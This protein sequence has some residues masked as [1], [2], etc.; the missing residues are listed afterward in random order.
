MIRRLI[1]MLAL[2]LAAPTMAA[3]PAGIWAFRIGNMT[4]FKI[5]LRHRGPDWSA[6]W[7]RSSD[8][9][10]DADGKLKTG[11]PIIKR[12]ATEARA[13]PDGT[14]EVSFDDPRPGATPDVFRIRL[15]DTRRA[16]AYYNGGR[17]GAI[18]LARATVK[19]R[20]DAFGRPRR[21]T[22]AAPDRDWP[23]NAEMIALFA[24]DQADRNVP[25]IDW[26][27]VG[28]RDQERRART[29][30]LIDAGALHSGDDFLHAAFVFQ[31]GSG[32][33]DFLKAHILATVAVAR[34]NRGAIW[35]ASATLDRYLQSIG[36]PQATGTQFSSRNGKWTQDPYNRT[37][38]SD[39]LRQALNVPPLDEQE[40]QRK[41]YEAAVKN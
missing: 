10:V 32:P 33:D 36:Q 25:H 40:A 39:A 16:E 14:V 3:D 11:G 8:L 1:L 34:G 37:L 17:M 12:A 29:Q 19:T 15:I 5:A 4:L 21:F 18:L 2:S 27:T 24:A 20:I 28:P 22:Y 31:H 9:D 6:T 26:A 41:R 13:N 7:F 23:T 30:Q 35:I 38:I